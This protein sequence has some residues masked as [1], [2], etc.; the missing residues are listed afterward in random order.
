MTLIELL[1]QLGLSELEARCYLALHEETNLS[2][3]EVAKRVSVS[4][5]NVYAALRSLTDKGGCRVIEG[6]PV[7]YDAVPIDQLI[8][9]ARTKFDQTAEI[10]VSRLNTPA[11]STPAFYNWQGEHH[12][13]MAIRRLAANAQQMIVVDI[14]AEDVHR[15]EEALLSAEKSGVCVVLI[16]LGE[17]HTPLRNVFVHKRDDSRPAD[18]AR[19]FTMLCDYRSALVGGFGGSVKTTALETDHPA[20]V[21]L[22][23]QAFYHDML[24]M[25]IEADFGEELVRKYG[26]QYEHIRHAYRQKG[27]FL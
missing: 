20:V 8:R 9:Y 3:Y 16:S 23:T 15:V 4:R 21:E 5:T 26:R 7:R 18:K 14:W 19:K 11:R 22:L 10:L 27:W 2:G 6:D 25:Q 24:M 13:D 17:T 12:L 1:K